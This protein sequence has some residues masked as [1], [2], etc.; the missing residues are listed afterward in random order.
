[1]T[2]N[3]YSRTEYAM[4]FGDELEELGHIGRERAIEYSVATS[5]NKP[6]DDP[7][8]YAHTLVAREVIV[9]EQV[10]EWVP[11]SVPTSSGGE[12]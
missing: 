9:T 12:S 3:T 1:M 4:D 11:V 10:G 7:E 8:L 2:P 6:S 5:S